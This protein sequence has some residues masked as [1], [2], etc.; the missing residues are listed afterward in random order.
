MKVLMLMSIFFTLSF[1]QS[2]LI[3]QD[4]EA[5][6]TQELSI[7]EAK[8]YCQS[9]KLNGYDDWRLPTI[10]ELFSIVDINKRAP[11]ITQDISRCADDY[12]W[13]ST[14]FVGDNYS[15]WSID[16]NSARVKSFNPNRSLHVRCVR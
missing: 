8:S 15:Y 10:K 3:W 9:L 5:V 11:A 1:S 16:F 4:D 6:I 13:S 2:N 7:D 14:I 12:Y